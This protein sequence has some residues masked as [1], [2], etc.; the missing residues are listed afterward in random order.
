MS[1]D[2]PARQPRRNLALEPEEKHEEFLQELHRLLGFGKP[3]EALSALQGMHPADQAAILEDLDAEDRE[4]L[5]LAMTP[6]G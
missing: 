6:E 5:L 2:V 1:S 3:G 4:A